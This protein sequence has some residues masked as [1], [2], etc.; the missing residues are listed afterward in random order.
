MNL[1]L[2]NS[3]ESSWEQEAKQNLNMLQSTKWK[4]D[5]TIPLSKHLERHRAAYT[6]LL[7]ALEHTA[8]EPSNKHQQVIYLT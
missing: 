6:D 3:S 4:G 5:T 8:Y 2:Q 1:E 7:E